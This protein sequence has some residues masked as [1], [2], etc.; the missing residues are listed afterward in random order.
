MSL[1]PKNSIEQSNSTDGI[2]HAYNE[3]SN[4]EKE[5]KMEEIMKG[6]CFTQL[7]FYDQ[8]LHCLLIGITCTVAPQI[9]NH[10]PRCSHIIH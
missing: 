10:F 3:Q 8:R 5:P 6:K 2:T 4:R 7:L 1:C 9:I